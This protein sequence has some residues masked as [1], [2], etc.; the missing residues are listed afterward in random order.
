MSFRGSR[1]MGQKEDEEPS[2]SGPIPM[3][4]EAQQLEVD[5]D[6]KEKR[7]DSMT[8]DEE[9]QAVLALDFDDGHQKVYVPLPGHTAMDTE[10]MDGAPSVRRMVNSGC[11]ICLCHFEP[12]EKITWSANPNCSHIFHGDCILHWYLAVGRKS[13]SRRLRRQPNMTDEEILSTLCDFPT[14][15]PSCRQN[16]CQDVRKLDASASLSSRTAME[17]DSDEEAQRDDL[18]ADNVETGLGSSNGS[19]SS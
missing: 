17:S 18:D 2:R 16:F 12:E 11:A 13:Q 1:K 5:Q 14:N 3:D 6:V 15:C 4:M 7:S 9:E 8:D 19:I 10:A